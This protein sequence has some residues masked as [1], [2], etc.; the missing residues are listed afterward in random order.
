VQPYLVVDMC[1]N[2]VAKNT[3]QLAAQ[4]GGGD[5]GNVKTAPVVVKLY[6]GDE[7]DFAAA[8]AWLTT[9]TSA[10]ASSGVADVIM[11]A[12]VVYGKAPALARTPH[13]PSFSLTYLP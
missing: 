11:L 10:A 9:T 4:S 13:T 7:G 8:D 5:E 3:A 1:A 2:N 12:D 6:W